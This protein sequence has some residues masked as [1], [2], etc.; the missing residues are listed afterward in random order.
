MS[1]VPGRVR[2][3][4]PPRRTPTRPRTRDLDLALDE[5]TPLGAVYLA[6]LLR[7]QL[8]LAARVLGLLVLSLG[9]LPLLLLHDGLARAE[10]LGVP[11][12]WVLLG[13][14][15]YPWLVLLGWVHVRRAE[16]HERDFVEI[17]ARRPR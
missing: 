11:L 6:S 3:T 16:R 8:G 12:A 5:E 10:V 15:V 2:V 13:G 9:A 17:V 1:E 7:A 4:G 14:V